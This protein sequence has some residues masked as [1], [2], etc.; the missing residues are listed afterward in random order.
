MGATVST[1]YYGNIGEETPICAAVLNQP[2]VDT[3]YA[4]DRVTGVLWGAF[5]DGI[6]ENM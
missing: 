5:D 2:A 4:A 6:G 3:Y 1:T